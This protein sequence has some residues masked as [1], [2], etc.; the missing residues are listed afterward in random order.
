MSEPKIVTR[1]EW[2]A[3]PW[4][5]PVYHIDIAARD[6]FFNHY[7]GGK[8]KHDRGVAMAKEVEAIHRAQGWAG[9]GYAFMVGQDGVGYE[10]RG[11]E[12]VGAHCPGFN[13]RGVSVYYAVGDDQEAS[14]AA[15]ATGRWLR[16]EHVRRRAKSVV[17]TF[18]GVEY[19]TSCCGKPTIAWVK[20]GMPTTAI[21][22]TGDKAPIPVK[23]VAK[24][25]IKAVL[26]KDGWLGTNTYRALQTRLITAG[27]SCGPGGANGQIRPATVQAL[28]RYLN[29]KL[30]GPDLRVDGEGFRQDGK[31]YLTIAALQRW[32]GMPQDGFLSS[33]SEAVQR[34]QDRLVRGNF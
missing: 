14:P 16:D 13:T 12:L 32:L 31:K 4:Q 5:R 27:F 24:A 29:A 21:E 17:T 8:P 2:G 11:W 22:P 30:G 34:M 25:P 20:A 19:P 26:V 28:Q 1:A 3:L 9:T 33:P 23:V 7:H 18:H 10:G 15:K 6:Y